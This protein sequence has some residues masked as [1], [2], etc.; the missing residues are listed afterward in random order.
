MDDDF[1]PQIVGRGRYLGN[2]RNERMLRFACPFCGEPVALWW[3]RGKSDHGPEHFVV[4]VCK[5][6]EIGFLH[7]EWWYY[8]DLEIDAAA[9]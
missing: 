4:A 9:R 2:V 6:E 7:D 5:A 8:K 1:R 3:L